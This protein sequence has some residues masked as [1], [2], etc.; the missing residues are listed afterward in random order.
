MTNPGDSSPEAAGIFHISH[1]QADPVSTDAANGTPDEQ[2]GPVPL[3]S[4]RPA[5]TTSARDTVTMAARSH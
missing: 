3:P 4:R 5:K 2:D 1:A